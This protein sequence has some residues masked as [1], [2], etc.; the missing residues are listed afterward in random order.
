MGIAGVIL[1]GGRSSRMGGADKAFALLGGEPLLLHAARRMR[2][3]GVE[4]IAVSS[5]A[6]PARLAGF[7]LEILPDAF[8][9]RPG[10][11]AGLHV[12][13][14]WAA[15][16]G[17]E[18]LFT[19]PVDTL[20]YPLDAP[21]R[22]AEAAGPGGIAVS[23]SGGRRHPIVALW[24]VALAERLEAH[25]ASGGS[26]RVNDFIDARPHAEVEFTAGSGAVDPFFNINRPADLA[27]AERLLGGQGL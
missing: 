8:P 3:S 5:N 18:T 19:A 11:L 25:L 13:L 17:A 16:L 27:E 23:G 14:C 7:G 22:L 12:G 9:D 2:E 20:F 10:P 24:P 26:R 6:D 1:A 4:A 15:W 21:A